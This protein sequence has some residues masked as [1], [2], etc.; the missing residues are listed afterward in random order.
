MPAIESPDVVTIDSKTVSS[1]P[2]FHLGKLPPFSLTGFIAAVA[3]LLTLATIAATGLSESGIRV[4]SQMAW[5]F[6]FFV[7]LAALVAGPLCR[8]APFALCRFIG[9][10]GRQLIWSF[11]AALG[12]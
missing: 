7:F 1:T 6:S 4:G 10:H 12:V 3:A 8:I 9:P 2:K 11:C 5:R